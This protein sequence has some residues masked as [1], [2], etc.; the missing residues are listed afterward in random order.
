MA[1]SA[2]GPTC[3]SDKQRKPSD[4][5]SDRRGE[6]S[7]G[8][9]FMVELRDTIYRRFDEHIGARA[10]GE[11][12]KNL[13]QSP[14]MNAKKASDSVAGTIGLGSIHLRAHDFISALRGP[15]YHDH[16]GATVQ[17]QVIHHQ[18]YATVTHLI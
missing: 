11:D 10:E 8:A 14:K 15:R 7:R 9:E 5:H 6:T 1:T 12:L 3:R 2:L 13:D 4:W 18:G 16:D 17:E